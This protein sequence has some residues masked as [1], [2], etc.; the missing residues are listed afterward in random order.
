MYTVH[1]MQPACSGGAHFPT[2]FQSPKLTVAVGA[3]RV[4]TQTKWTLRLQLLRAETA[5][6]TTLRVQSSPFQLFTSILA[7][8]FSVLGAWKLV[9][10]YLEGPINA[11]AV[12]LGLNIGSSYAH[13][14]GASPFQGMS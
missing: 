11:L 8:L 14:G 2:P 13:E 7:S 3:Q 4:T 9:F 6:E 10:M 1:V 12:K 5:Y